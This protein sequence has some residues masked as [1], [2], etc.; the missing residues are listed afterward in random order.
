MLKYVREQLEKQGL[1]TESAVD[2]NDIDDSMFVEAAHVLDELNELSENGTVDNSATRNPISI[3]LEDDIE[4]DTVEFCMV[5]SRMS[6]IPGD[7]ALQ[8]AYYNDLKKFSDFYAEAYSS[9]TQLPRESYESF[10]N[11]VFD[12]QHQLYNKYMETVVQEG[13]FGFGEIKLNSEEIVWNVHLNFGKL[14][15]DGNEEFNATLPVLYEAKK[16]KILKKQLEAVKFFDY[17]KL[18]NAREAILDY[19]EKNGVKIPKDGNVW[20]VIIPNAAFIPREQNNKYTMYLRY[21]VTQTGEE[22]FFGVTAIMGSKSKYDGKSMDTN[23]TD[24][25]DMKFDMKSASKPSGS[26]IDKKTFTESYVEMHMPSRWGN[27]YYQ[28]AIDFGGGGDPPEMAGAPAAEP[29]G[30]T[31]PAPAAPTPTPEAAPE[32]NNAQPNETNINID[33]P[34]EEGQGDQGGDMNQDNNQPNDPPV[35]ENPNTNDVSDQIAA[36]VNE[37]LEKQNSEGAPDLSADF[38]Q[39]P[40]FDTSTDPTMDAS[41]LNADD[42]PLDDTAG[43]PE[44]PDEGDGSI[45]DADFDKMTLNQLI[46]QAQEKAKDMTIDQLKAFLMNNTMPNGEE[47]GE[48]APED[49]VQEAFIYTK[50][51]INDSLDVLLRTA[52]GILNDDKLE[53]SKLVR[54]FKKNGKKLNKCLTKAIKMDVYTEQEKKQLSLMNRCLIDLMSVIKDNS[55][56]SNTLTTKRLVK[57]FTSQA[58]AVGDIV[59]KHKTGKPVQD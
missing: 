7:A 8:E 54:K 2:N 45:E 37:E 20:D 51:N 42:L 40:N 4:I 19:A 38:N 43:E 24:S 50:S 18:N 32:T 47:V 27:N 16:E 35:P 31:P 52:L 30:A 34:P 10:E 59:E 57:A 21:K 41:S 55:S 17:S 53:L 13:L 5:D 33:L 23:I 36:G 9:T 28:E 14:R 39:E 15:N 29:T 46:E 12:R 25:K 49:G 26:Y 48:G 1:F 56:P 3:P 22:I 6:D 58:K 11:R 44:L